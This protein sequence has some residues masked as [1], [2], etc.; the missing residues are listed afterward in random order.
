ME[1]HNR[2][3][4]ASPGEED[5]GGIYDDDNNDKP[6]SLYTRG[7]KVPE[8]IKS[9]YSSFVTAMLYVPSV[10]ACV[11][12]TASSSTLLLSK[13]LAVIIT[14]LLVSYTAR[15]MYQGA[16][17]RRGYGPFILCLFAFPLVMMQPILQ[18]ML[19]LRY[20]NSYEPMTRLINV[21]SWLGL[22]QMSTASMW[23]AS[24]DVYVLDWLSRQ[25]THRVHTKS[26]AEAAL[27]EM[28]TVEELEPLAAAPTVE[29]EEECGA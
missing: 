12:T 26:N 19:S 20:Y 23:N 28:E 11:G 14:L 18:V 17:R 22:I 13:K 27:V 15:S 7:F 16:T 8:T 2:H 10:F 3:P 21:I 24:L 1:M 4:H 25:W 5:D 29:E 6:T 9:I